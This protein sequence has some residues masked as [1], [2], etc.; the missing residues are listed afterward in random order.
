MMLTLFKNKCPLNSFS[1]LNFV[2]MKSIEL[3]SNIPS[4]KIVYH[5]I[6]QLHS[7]YH[8]VSCVATAFSS[9]ICCKARLFINFLSFMCLHS[10]EITNIVTSSEIIAA[11]NRKRF[12]TKLWKKKFFARQFQFCIS[13]PFFANQKFPF[14]VE[15]GEQIFLMS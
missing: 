14:S 2:T 3:K 13:M 15:F 12:T 7:I 4:I 5:H 10:T 1:F 11:T 8:Y 9:F 6:V